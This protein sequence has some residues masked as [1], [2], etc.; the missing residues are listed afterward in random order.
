MALNS[1]ERM[2]SRNGRQS[3]LPFPDVIMTI[4][5]GTQCRF[6]IVQMPG[7][8]TV[9]PDD[10]IELLDRV[11]KSFGGGNIESG[12]KQVCGIQASGQTFLEL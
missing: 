11:P 9:A 1:P 6:G 8:K 3:D 2:I 12:F 7:R 10:S 5:A 4:H